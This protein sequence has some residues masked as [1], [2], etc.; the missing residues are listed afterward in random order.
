MHEREREGERDPPSQER[1]NGRERGGMKK[2][3]NYEWG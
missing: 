1:E 2:E 3:R